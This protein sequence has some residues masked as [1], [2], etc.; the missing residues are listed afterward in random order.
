MQLPCVWQELQPLPEV[1]C[2]STSLGSAWRSSLN[3]VQ[4]RF[5]AAGPR[6]SGS[7]DTT[8]QAA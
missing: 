3:S 4:A 1:A 8:S 2:R 5:S 6:Y 7:Q